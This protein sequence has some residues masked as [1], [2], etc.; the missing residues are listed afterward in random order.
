M[1]SFISP[2]INVI[3]D[4]ILLNCSFEN[5]QVVGLKDSGNLL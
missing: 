5:I 1:N 4:E 3:S 2:C